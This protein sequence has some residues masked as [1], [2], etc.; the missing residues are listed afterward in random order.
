MVD[1]VNLTPRTRTEKQH[2]TLLQ[3]MYINQ[4]ITLAV[5]H[6]TWRVSDE[7]GPLHD[8]FV[9]SYVTRFD[10]TYHSQKIKHSAILVSTRAELYAER[11]RPKRRA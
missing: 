11:N 9:F 10:K 1:I 5:L 3:G 7:G 6:D 4:C 8:A 2:F